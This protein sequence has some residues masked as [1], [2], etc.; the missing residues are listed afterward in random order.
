MTPSDASPDNAPSFDQDHRMDGKLDIDA[1]LDFDDNPGAEPITLVELGAELES[2]SHPL[3]YQ[4]AEAEEGEAEEEAQEE[5]ED[6]DEK[7]EDEEAEAEYEREE[8]QEEED[9]EEEEEEDDEEFY[10]LEQK[11]DPLLEMREELAASG[12]ESRRTARRQMDVL[13]EFGTAIAAVGSMVRDLHLSS[14][15]ATPKTAAASGTE[16][17]LLPLIEMAD[18]LARAAEASRT[19]PA[20]ITTSWWSSPRT[21]LASWQTAWDSQKDALFILRSHMDTLL[22]R[23][24]LERIPAAGTVFDP[25]SMS[26]VEVHTDPTLPDHTVIAEVLSGWRLASGGRIIRPAQV[27]VS[28]IS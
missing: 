18:R 4:A 27:K 5:K 23:A 1:K 8:D 3:E 26:A 24:G 19:P 12:A 22:T 10:E 20:A 14:R 15:T 11:P 13:K 21:A 6:E 7:E 17:L 16:S 28:R 9:Q 25:S 2:E